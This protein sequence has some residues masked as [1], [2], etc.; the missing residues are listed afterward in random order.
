MKK[1]SKVFATLAA[2]AMLGSLFMA[3]S[4][5]DGEKGDGL[6]A[7]GKYETTVPDRLTST[8]PATA[9]EVKL[10]DSVVAGIKEAFA[11]ITDSSEH[12]ITLAPGTYD[13]GTDQINYNGG[14]TI[15]V[16]GLGT[17]EYGTDVLITTAREELASEE[18]RSLLYVAGAAN[19]YLENLTLENSNKKVGDAQFEVLGYA[20]SGTVAAYN[21]S[22]LSH[23]DTVR[24][25]GKAWF[26]KCYIEGDVDFLWMEEAGSVALYENCRLR[27]VKDRIAEDGSCNA[28]FTAPRMSVADEKSY[29][30]GLVII[31]SAFEVEDGVTAYLGRNPWNKSG[32]IYNNVSIVR[33][34]LAGKI[35]S[36][37]KNAGNANTA[38]KFTGF[39]TDAY[40][41][42]DA[43]NARYNATMVSNEF[44]GRNNIINRYF[45]GEVSAMAK[46]SNI[47]DVNALAT[48]LNW[49]VA[50]DTSV[51][52]LPTEKPTNVYEY[53]F[54]GATNSGDGT[55]TTADGN[56]TIKPFGFRTDIHGVTIHKDD[57]I[58]FKVATM[59]KI[60]FIACQYGASFEGTATTDVGTFS[61][62]NTT[63]TFKIDPSAVDGGVSGAIFYTG[64]TPAT[65]T[66]TFTQAG[67]CYLHG[68]G[69]RE[70]AEFN[71]ASSITVSGASSLLIDSTAQLSA[72][73]KP[74]NVTLKAVTW[75]SSDESVALVSKKG[76]V[77]GL[78]AGT[79]TI[80]CAATDGSGVTGTKVITVK[81][82][83]AAPKAGQTYFYN[84]KGGVGNPFFSSDTFFQM[85]ADA[86]NGGHGLQAGNGSTIKLKVAGNVEIDFHNC[87][88]DNA[89]D[90]I[91]TNSKGEVV[92]SVHFPGQ[93]KYAVEPQDIF[94]LDDYHNSMAYV[95][96][97]D[98]LTLTYTNAGGSASYLHDLTV[99]P[100][101]GIV[102]VESIT[103]TAEGG[104]TEVKALETLQLT[105]TV[106]PD[107]ATAKL[108]TWSSSNEEIATVNSDGLVTALAE[109]DVV[110]TAT[111][112]A[113]K[114][115]KGEFPLTVVAGSKAISEKTV[116]NFGSSGNY[117]DLT[118]VDVSAAALRDNGGNNSQFSSGTI[119]FEVLK[120][121]MI[122][123]STYS[124]YTSYKVSDGT[125][126]SEEQTGTSFVYMAT[127]DST[128]TVTPTNSNNYFYSITV[129]YP[130]KGA[131]TFGSA[132]NYKDLTNVDFSAANLRDNGGD[133]SQFSSGTITFDVVA[134]S[135]ITFATYNG[136]TAYT[137]SDGENTSDEQT[138]TS[139]VY[140]ATKSGTI[141]VT[142]TNSNNYFYSI[143]VE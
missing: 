38:I 130:L 37:F 89:C 94:K 83:S 88:Y 110:I 120:G 9:G 139:F 85:F 77:Q 18:S 103:V 7:G 112:V 24:T 104:A 70:Y 87:R 21:C 10:D 91:A 92:G 108:V 19:I 35:K 133:N 116:I 100:L 12:T 80:T 127:A 102:N 41:A 56:V 129:S 66:L 49:D 14:A 122:S 13:L 113:D 63:T 65:I 1:L 79:T 20:G 90:V 27:A 97:A 33:S 128:I 61:D 2:V 134:G 5:D 43:N 64:T 78:K 71:K 114:N 136:Y 32:S 52:V 117:K 17:A 55:Y 69:I 96:P 50:A 132:G 31:D 137:V 138:G 58:T 125:N 45:D 6:P 62:G 67:E 93:E 95:G 15:H 84:L 25:T 142:P 143:T 118:K 26:Y 28:Y 99:K 101:T 115:M 105:A 140:N 51:N 3:C 30:K 22:F 131:V 106:S 57:T 36:A 111:S 11:A 54:V 16:K 46:A 44:A 86:D 74:A 68:V 4:S 34:T 123:F 42:A 73:I 126:E 119:S 81:A 135:V 53:S 48:K 72:T 60:S 98:T 109:G 40:F 23:Q 47:W 141:T 75:S 76:L 29:Y 82:N 39:H 124:G 59:C 8:A 107:N 121:A